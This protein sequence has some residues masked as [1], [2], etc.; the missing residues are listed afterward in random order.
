MGGP[1]LPGR[2][3]DEGV[4]LTFARVAPQEELATRALPA[5]GA[6]PAPCAVHT[7]STSARAG[8]GERRSRRAEAARARERPGIIERSLL[9]SAHAVRSRSSDDRARL[10]VPLRRRS[11]GWLGK[12]LPVSPVLQ[13]T[14]SHLPH[15]PE[16]RPTTGDSRWE[17]RIVERR[18][19]AP[20]I[21]TELHRGGT[22]C[23]RV[24][25]TRWQR[26]GLFE[27][28]P[29][30]LNAVRSRFTRLG[31]RGLACRVARQS[32]IHPVA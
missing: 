9:S 19:S 24:N 22:E 5:P 13:Y 15:G 23:H 2:S 16:D 10:P 31:P 32:R 3:R 18:C 14:M 6:R 1:W 8:W 20:R 26:S 27:L 4:H 12:T 25:Q 29:M 28:V 17:A 30:R 11:S 21:Y 7:S